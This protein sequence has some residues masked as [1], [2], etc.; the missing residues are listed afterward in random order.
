MDYQRKKFFVISTGTSILGNFVRSN[1]ES[2]R[3]K[4]YSMDKWANL[5][6]ND[7]LQRKIENFI[8]KGNE[9]HDS[10]LE[11]VMNNPKDASAELNSFLSFL[12][13]YMIKKE[14][15]EV[16]IYSTDTSN[17][18]LTAQIVYEYLQGEGFR[19]VGNVVVVDNFGV[20]VDMFELGLTNLLD[21][22]V[23]VLKSKVDQGY[24][25]YVN[26]TAGYKPETTFLV[27]ASML[28][29]KL[30]P[31]VFYQHEAFKE[32]IIL[33]LIPIVISKEYKEVA[34]K[35]KEPTP[36]NEAVEYLKK[37]GYNLEDLVN[38][39]ILELDTNRNLVQTRKWLRKLLELN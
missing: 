18:R 16:L 20:S 15:I 4:K 7:P 33:P 21:K 39:K 36:Q 29:S 27:L 23:G 32:P 25:I 28:V 2:E 22:V 3:V 10:L 35:F 38:K 31:I 11:F 24:E 5:A 34:E 19:L 17:N 30:S 13:K 14:D 37:K 9:V 8:P 6:P 12:E 1:K 26:A